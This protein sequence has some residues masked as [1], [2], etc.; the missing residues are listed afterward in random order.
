MGKLLGLMC[1]F[2]VISSGISPESL[3]AQEESTK[4]PSLVPI[5]VFT[6][7]HYLQAF[8][9]VGEK[10]G[11]YGGSLVDLRS[12]HAGVYFGALDQGVLQRVPAVSL[13]FRE[14]RR[15]QRMLLRSPLEDGLDSYRMEFVTK[16]SSKDDPAFVPSGRLVVEDLNE[17]LSVEFHSN[18]DDLKILQYL[19]QESSGRLKFDSTNHVKVAYQMFFDKERLAHLVIERTSSLFP[20][21]HFYSA[22]ERV[23]GFWRETKVESVQEPSVGSDPDLPI[24]L[25]LEY[26]REIQIRSRPERYVPPLLIEP[27]KKGRPLTEVQLSYGF[28]SGIAY[29]LSRLNVAKI[30]LCSQ[31]F[32]N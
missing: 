24:I 8:V 9:L 32:E 22:M 23:E 21:M 29:D 5:M 27:G 30:G 1:A 13:A 25:K 12:R 4:S 26:G 10:H 17:D 7:P 28:P 19:S 2:V 16:L 18:A 6:N 15:Y 14:D 20:D 31:L 3:S 11:A